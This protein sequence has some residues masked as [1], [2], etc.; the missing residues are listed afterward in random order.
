MRIDYTKGSTRDELTDDN[1]DAR[2][3]KL[4]S[5]GLIVEDFRRSRALFKDGRFLAARDLT[6]EQ[7]YALSRE[8]DLSVVHHGGVIRGLSLS[9]TGD[10]IRVTAGTG[11][12]PNGELVSLTKALAASIRNVPEDDRIDLSHGLVDVAE[13][14]LASRTGLY[15]L[16]LRP[17]E[18]TARPTPR[19]P[20]S[21]FGSAGVEDGDIVEALSLALH[22]LRVDASDDPALL[23]SELARRIFLERGSDLPTDTLALA[24][25]FLRN[26]SIDWLDP[27]LVRRDVTADGLVSVGLRTQQRAVAEAHFLQHDRQLAELVGD[28]RGRGSLT[29]PAA[30]YFRCLPPVGR[31]PVA[32]IDA[33]AFTQA[34]FPPQMTVTLGVVV[35][36]EVPAL[37]ESA[38][39]L[40]AIDLEGPDDDLDY[41]S[42]RILVPL[43]AAEIDRL[44]LLPPAAPKRELSPAVVGGGVRDV[45]SVRDRLT[46]TLVGRRLPG[47]SLRELLI[48]RRI[49][50]TQGPDFGTEQRTDD[51]LVLSAWRQA[52]A[53]APDQLVWFVRVPTL[54]AASTTW[55]DSLPRPVTP[56]PVTPPPVTPTPVTPTPITPTPVTPTPVIVTPTPVTPTP[57]TPTPVVVTPTPVTPTPVVVT[58]TPVTPTPVVVTPTPV[59]PTPVVVTPT[60][61]HPV[62]PIGP[63]TPT[64]VVVTP[65][66]PTPVTPVVHPVTPI[67]PVTPTPVVV[68]PTPVHPVTPIGPTPV[69]VTPTPVTPVVHPV[70]PI[71][72]VTPTPV[73]FTPT[74]VTPVPHPV[75]PTP[76][77]P[78]VHPVTPTPVHPITPVPHPGIPLTPHPITPIGPTPI[79]GP[80]RDDGEDR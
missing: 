19:Y 54:Q 27:F 34:Y 14:P 59:T 64:P 37:I 53:A 39:D 15:L 42:I 51:P 3:A 67:G 76:V 49:P 31:M 41:T 8:A 38:I 43:P 6:R 46:S 75:T 7:S 21:T 78:V 45:L 60:P 17:G 50:Q 65:I 40:P 66:S 28:L 12:T 48:R 35:D 32:A 18:Y 36:E 58:P 63:L 33:A 25:V 13:P 10:I 29:F 71:G 2:L 80:G 11:F 1:D 69:I 56:T 79:R 4:R 52:L 26:G 62:T 72:P 5:A 30:R 20:L 16:G 9:R 24:I 23:R 22:P 47:D 77:T 68:T 57:V 73:V 61:V 70:T 44:Q 74:P 55:F